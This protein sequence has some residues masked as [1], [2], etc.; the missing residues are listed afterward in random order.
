[1]HSSPPAEIL[2]GAQDS[3]PV[4][5]PTV[6]ETLRVLADAGD[7]DPVRDLIRT[8]LAETH[9]RVQDLEHA[10]KQEDGPV[11]RALAHL[12]RGS[13][14][15]LGAGRLAGV[16]RRIEELAKQNEFSGAL[17]EMGSLRAEFERV[18]EAFQIEL[19]H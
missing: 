9:T 11:T 1:M 10:V 13:S 8:Y 3:E 2:E 12:I 14:S 6:L 17:Q 15:S 18:Q 4:L 19:A 7:P 16:A 5:D